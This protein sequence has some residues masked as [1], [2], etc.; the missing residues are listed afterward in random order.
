M[1]SEMRECPR[2]KQYYHKKYFIEHEFC[3]N[4]LYEIKREE[5][6]KQLYDRI[7]EALKDPMKELE[8]EDE[9]TKSE[10]DAIFADWMEGGWV[11][12][13][14]HGWIGPLLKIVYRSMK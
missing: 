4:C 2:C 10:I 5:E 13:M 6:R 9:L 14:V 7:N 3:Y 12:S 11:D 8:S 1:D